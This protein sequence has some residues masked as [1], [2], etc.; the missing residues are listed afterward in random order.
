MSYLNSSILNS[1]GENTTNYFQNEDCSDVWDPV[2]KVDLNKNKED[3]SRIIEEF[4][5][6]KSDPNYFKKLRLNLFKLI[7]KISFCGFSLTYLLIFI[8][9]NLFIYVFF[10]TIMLIITIFIM[11]KKT[12]ND[13]IID[14]LKYRIAKKKNWEYN[15][16]ETEDKYQKLN[17]IDNSCFQFIGGKNPVQLIFDQF[18]GQKKIGHKE[19]KFT[20]GIAKQNSLLKSY[21]IIK[22]LKDLPVEFNLKPSYVNCKS[23]IKLESTSFNQIFSI[24]LY[25]E[26]DE[27]LKL[28]IYKILSPAV[29]ENLINLRKQF[30]K[31]LYVHFKKDY[32]IF[33][34]YKLLLD[35]IETNLEKDGD[36]NQND[37]NKFNR[38]INNFVQIANEVVKYQD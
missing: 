4:N 10:I 33:S 38:K 27:N 19:Y 15:P 34:S 16:D 35:K 21:I 25:K 17:K 22:L 32:I 11:V 29:Q 36:L 5:K 28:K 23:D 6:I 3:C 8:S 24:N 20:L 31:G 7:F 14:V 13:L 12:H 26:N 37:L 9:G 18:W 1:R 30:G 2:E